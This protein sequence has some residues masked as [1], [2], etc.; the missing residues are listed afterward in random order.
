MHT[1]TH[2]PRTH[3][4]GLHRCCVHTHCTHMHTLL[5]HTHTLQGETA[6]SPCAHT[7]AHTQPCSEELQPCCL[8]THTSV[9]ACTHCTDADTLAHTSTYISLQRDCSL[10]CTHTHTSM[11]THVSTHTHMQMCTRLHTQCTHLLTHA[12]LCRQGLQ[13][14]CA[15][16]HTHTHTAHT[17]TGLTH[18]SLQGRGVQPCRVH[19]PT[20]THTH[21]CTCP[22]TA[23]L[24][25]AHTHT[26]ATHRALSPADPHVLWGPPAAPRTP[27]TPPLCAALLQPHVH[28]QPPAHGSAARRGARGG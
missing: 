12:H 21:I 17:C 24:T 3:L 2:N 6:T 20:H 28:P 26:G 27:P 8:H 15:H 4:Q 13:L 7:H 14:H 23:P 10:L 25:A 5:T 11:H 19:T 1:H 18:T 22:Y 16:T 9:Q